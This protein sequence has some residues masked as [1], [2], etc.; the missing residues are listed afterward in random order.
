MVAIVLT[1][2]STG[3]VQAHMGNVYPRYIFSSH[4]SL[5]DC[6]YHESFFPE[7]RNLPLAIF[8]LLCLNCVRKE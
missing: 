6:F 4:F 1:R 3:A 7:T 2:K 5:G 8:I